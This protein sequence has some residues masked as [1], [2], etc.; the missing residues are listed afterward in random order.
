MSD[1]QAFQLRDYATLV[2]ELLAQLGG[3]GTT[4]D[5]G[6]GVRPAITD[7]T[8]GSVVR[9]LVEAF[10]REL[11]V[12]YQQLAHVYRDGYVDTATG[13]ALD[14]VVALLG[15]ER[16]G[17][18]ST[19]GTVLFAREQPA[20]EEIPIPQGT[21]VSGP[22]APILR[23]TSDVVLPKGGTRVAVTVR[24]QDGFSDT[25]PVGAVSIMPRPL[26]GISTVSNPD[27]LQARTTP[28][29]DEELRRRSKACL[30][31]R[32]RG[33]VDAIRESVRALG[34]ESVLIQ[35][36]IPDKPGFLRVVVGAGDEVDLQ[37]VRESV[38]RARPAGVLLEVAA[39]H[40]VPFDIKADLLL[41]GEP[42]ATELADL[43]ASLAADLR[44]YVDGLGVNANVRSDKV[45]KI[46]LA[47]A[48]VLDAVPTGTYG[49]FETDEGDVRLVDTDILIGDDE[50]PV[51][52]EALLELQPE[53]L[54]VW[55]DVVVTMPQGSG[56]DLRD[57]LEADA[58]EMASAHLAFAV[59]Q[60]L[61]EFTW[62]GLRNAL[63]GQVTG[64]ATA[65]A[66]IVTYDRDGVVVHLE[67]SGDGIHILER[68]EAR[69]RRV[70]VNEEVGGG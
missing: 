51:L 43:R 32:H 57:R 41:E 26:W 7:T 28:E 66:F 65:V 56:Q 14:Q 1:E 5:G 33:T 60:R 19:E 31:G 2:Q 70:A 40:D 64:A 44:A 46:L 61:R 27:R 25:L 16:H 34:H 39:A 12:A 35:E 67:R 29:T 63:G 62:E 52:G 49:Y 30:T 53:A 38:E 58:R 68:E 23:T 45:R 20:P 47:P 18:G 9:T 54:P 11:A 48:P 50:R 3:E 4:H 21:M 59:K 42:S 36:R 22:K 55:F 69:L 37:A 6:D 8:P 17:G 15:I 24:A 13:K 10:S